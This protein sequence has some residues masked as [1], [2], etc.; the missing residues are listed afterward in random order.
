MESSYP[1]TECKKECEE[2]TIQCEKCGKWSHINCYSELK[3]KTKDELDK[4]DF[5]C[6][7]CNNKKRKRDET[8]DEKRRERNKK[9][10]DD[11]NKKLLNVSTDIKNLR[12]KL[13]KIHKLGK[14]KSNLFEE[15]IKNLDKLIT[16][17]ETVKFKEALDKEVLDNKFI[18]ED[19]ELQLSLLLLEKMTEEK[20][21]IHNVFT[22]VIELFNKGEPTI[23]DEEI[24]K[25]IHDLFK[26][27]E[28]KGKRKKSKSKRK[29]SKRKSIK[30]RK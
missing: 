2:N 21:I 13:D 10:L 27:K 19:D 18:K 28:D 22:K 1:C 14:N 25:Y 20:N 24:G 8:D 12:D 3:D 30:K 29:K 6:K 26:G 9:R 17:N 15:E 5:Y 7:L 23:K 11:L 4:L 16:E